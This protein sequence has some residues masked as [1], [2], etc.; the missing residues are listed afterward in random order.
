MIPTAN[1]I[2]ILYTNLVKTVRRKKYAIYKLPGK[3]ETDRSTDR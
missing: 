1:M 2:F 3:W